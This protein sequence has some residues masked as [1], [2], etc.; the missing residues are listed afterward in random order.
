VTSRR[1]AA[2]LL[3]LTLP[4]SSCAAPPDAARGPVPQETAAAPA[5]SLVPSES[6][7]PTEAA[8]ANGPPEPSVDLSTLWSLRRDPTFSEV[9]RALD[10]GKL[11]L[12]L[13]A[14][15]RLVA[16]ETSASAVRLAL[17]T[18]VHATLLE[19]AGKPVAALAKYLEVTRST[20]PLA[21]AAKLRAARLQ[22]ALGKDEAAVELVSTIAPTAFDEREVLAATAVSLARAAPIDRVRAACEVLYLPSGARRPGW[23][24]EGL[25]VLGSLARR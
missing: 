24:V 11:E 9:A 1:L 8:A 4:W 10:D 17:T 13:G 16:A 19:R 18:Y 23:S 2:G 6:P 7:Q 15:E 3:A 5:P 20:H 25:R 14:L 12:A 22:A 21:D